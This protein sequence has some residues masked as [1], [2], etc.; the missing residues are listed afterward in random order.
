M[1][2]TLGLVDV[3]VGGV[4]GVAAAATPPE[5]QHAALVVFE[6]LIGHRS[7]GS[8]SAVVTRHA[9]ADLGGA[10]DDRG[11]VVISTRDGPDRRNGLRAGWRGALV[12]GRASG[13]VSR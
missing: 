3:I 13:G 5:P 7:V 10:A 6:P 1:S 8:P 2:R 12:P 11:D 4:R 9:G